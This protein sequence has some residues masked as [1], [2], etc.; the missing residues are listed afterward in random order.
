[1][2]TSII[3]LLS[4]I[5][6]CMSLSGCVVSAAFGIATSVVGGAIDVVDAVTPDIFDDEDDD[7]DKNEEDPN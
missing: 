1:M 5:I 3:N 7:E 4:V 6:F 2:R